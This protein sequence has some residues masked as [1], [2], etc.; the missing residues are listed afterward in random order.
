MYSDKITKKS[1]L[2]AVR[3]HLNVVEPTNSTAS[4]EI[5]NTASAPPNASALGT[6]P[7]A[8]SAHSI[9]RDSVPT[10][11]RSDRSLGTNPQAISTYQWE[12]YLREI[13]DDSDDFY[14][15]VND[16]ELAFEE[17]CMRDCKFTN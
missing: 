7:Q 6:N 4:S 15:E 2:E 11:D 9:G 3:L 10:S 13:D 8:I 5:Q 1:I 14:V 16:D 12:D 17:Y